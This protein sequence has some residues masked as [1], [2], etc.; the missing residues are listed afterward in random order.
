MSHLSAYLV[1]VI[2]ILI[3]QQPLDLL[4]PPV[5]H[6]HQVLP[7]FLIHPGLSHRGTFYDDLKLIRNKELNASPA[8]IIAS[9]MTTF[10]LSFLPT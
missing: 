6:Q 10:V 1:E 5:L 4:P 3:L 2:L 9:F 8:P 7:F